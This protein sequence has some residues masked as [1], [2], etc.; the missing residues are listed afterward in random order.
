MQAFLNCFSTGA[1]PFQRIMLASLPFRIGRGGHVHFAVPTDRVSRE[2]AEFI[3]HGDRIAIRDLGSTNGT[4]VNGTRIGAVSEL[5]DGDVVHIDTMEFQLELNP[6][7]SQELTRI[8]QS[9]FQVSEVVAELLNPENLRVEFQPIVK[10]GEDT[11][12]GYEG[13]GRFKGDK[14]GLGARELFRVADAFKI[15]RELSRMLRVIAI[16]QAL[17]LPP[18]EYLFL[19]IHS[20]ELTPTMTLVKSLSE[21]VGAPPHRAKVVVEIH[22]DAV[23]EANTILELRN[24]LVGLNIGLAFD[25]FGVG[26]SRLME[27][28]DSPPDFVKLDMKLIRGIEHS[29]ARKNLVSGLA[30]SIRNLGSNVIAEGIQ[31]RAEADTCL[32]LSCDYGQ[33]YHFGRPGSASHFSQPK[34]A[35]GAL[36]A[37]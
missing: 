3:N 10:L 5:H 32:S 17:R 28:S 6:D 14:F 35:V 11:I 36:A 19:N 24:Q 27:L 7:E 37:N 26:R 20:V 16:E 21:Q 4:F 34:A 18:H 22:E 33:G 29:Q 25:D 8:T 2:H 1:M 30:A 31:S 12:L 13:L 23:V 9:G 15:G